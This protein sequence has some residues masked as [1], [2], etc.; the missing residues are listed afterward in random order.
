LNDTRTTGTN[1]ESTSVGTCSIVSCLN[2]VEFNVYRWANCDTRR[3]VRSQIE[4]IIGWRV[5]SDTRMIVDGLNENVARSVGHPSLA[6]IHRT[7]SDVCESLTSRYGNLV[8]GGEIPRFPDKK[9]IEV[10]VGSSGAD[11]L[12]YSSSHISYPE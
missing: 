12:F 6:S 8:S 3:T 9:R 5:I 7:V 1:V 2:T 4:P 10:R 11:C